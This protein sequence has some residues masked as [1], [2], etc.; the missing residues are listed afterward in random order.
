MSS[1][2]S[3]EA[4]NAPSFLVWPLTVVV[5][6]FPLYRIMKHYPKQFVFAIVATATYSLNVQEIFQYLF[7]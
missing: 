4:D 3:Y 1:L 6:S 7:A 5:L 2:Q